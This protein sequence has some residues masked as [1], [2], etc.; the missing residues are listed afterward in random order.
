MASKRQ[1]Y[2]ETLNAA[3][4][5]VIKKPEKESSSVDSMIDDLESSI[6]TTKNPEPAPEPVQK[7][8]ERPS[9]E[10]PSQAAN[11]LGLKPKV[12]RKI[13]KS[14]TRDEDLNEK[15]VALAKDNG[16]S[17]NEVLNRILEQF[18]S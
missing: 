6:D 13:R 12:Y 4:N 2:T 17:E 8:R 18:F 5:M 1:K 10:K 16:V 14:F 7:E 3:K 9:A 15:F 11:K